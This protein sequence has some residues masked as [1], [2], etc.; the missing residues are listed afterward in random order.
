MVHK[1]WGARELPL[2]H[3]R[4]VCE[5]GLCALKV[6]RKAGVLT[7]AY[8]RVEREARTTA[9]FAKKNSQLAASARSDERNH[10][11]VFKAY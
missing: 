8:F 6:K 10:A 9:G 2:R 4:C 5:G 7:Q 3:T 11:Q 1:V